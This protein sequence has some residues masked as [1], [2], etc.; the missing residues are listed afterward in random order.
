MARTIQDLSD[1]IFIHMANFTLVRCDSY[2]LFE[3]RDQAAYTG[4][5]KELTS[6]DELPITKFMSCQGGREIVHYEKRSSGSSHKKAGG[7]HHYSQTTKQEPDTDWKSSPPAWK[8]QK[9]HG[10]GKKG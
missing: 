1:C 5:P 4:H 10:Q 6:S 8:Q 2:G 9:H 7:Y 3:S